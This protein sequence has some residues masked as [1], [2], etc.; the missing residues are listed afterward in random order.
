MSELQAVRCPRPLLD[1]GPVPRW[2]PADLPSGFREE[3]AVAPHLHGVALDAK[4]HGDVVGADGVTGHE[5][6]MPCNVRVDKCNDR[7]YGED[8]TNDGIE[9]WQRETLKAEQAVRAAQ[10]EID[11]I[12]QMRETAL[13]V[14]THARLRVIDCEQAVADYLAIEYP[15]RVAAAQSQWDRFY[16]EPG[17]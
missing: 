1:I 8:M 15:A 7:R 5:V 10:A 3:A 17:R 11:R 13:N 12:L 14:L 16:R 9:Y 4:A 6:I 2:S